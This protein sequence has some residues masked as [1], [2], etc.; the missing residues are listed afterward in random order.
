M[1]PFLRLPLYPAL[2]CCLLLVSLPV[3]AM[4]PI[5]E[6][7]T[8]I[9]SSDHSKALANS[10]PEQDARAALAKG[11]LRLLGFASRAT[12]L[13]GVPLADRQAALD[14]CDVR[15]MEGFSDVVRSDK[16]LAS[17]GLAHD[18]AVRYNAVVLAQCLKKD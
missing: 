15:F 14:V 17:R 10:N 16:E 8:N 7:A 1:N 2:C 11:D 6:D 3:L 12:S 9:T 5:I 4:S 18:Y 13:P